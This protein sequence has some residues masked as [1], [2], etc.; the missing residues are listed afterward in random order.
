MRPI[1]TRIDR[2]YIGNLITDLKAIQRPTGDRILGIQGS[3]NAM[4]ALKL[5]NPD[6]GHF[7]RDCSG[8][9]VAR[10]YDE[11]TVAEIRSRTKAVTI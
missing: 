11:S 8:R 10:N 2:V 4:N 6:G 9:V 3:K 7:E 5:L 1:E